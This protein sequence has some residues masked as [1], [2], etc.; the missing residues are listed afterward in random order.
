LSMSPSASSS[1][2][3]STPRR[4]A[5]RPRL[6]P[7]NFRRSQRS[8]QGGETGVPPCCEKIELCSVNSILT[9]SPLLLTDN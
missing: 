5:S 2:P 6:P 1:P 3:S 9:C 7:I 4:Y 8:Y